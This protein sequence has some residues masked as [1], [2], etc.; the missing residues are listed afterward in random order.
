MK[1]KETK[2]FGRLT[3]SRVLE[4]VRRDDPKSPLNSRSDI[5]LVA[6]SVGAGLRSL[7]VRSNMSRL[8][9]TYNDYC[10]NQL[11]SLKKSYC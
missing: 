4:L 5:M 6:G 7:T 10:L 1:S 11:I 3:S 8:P 9:R 2:Q